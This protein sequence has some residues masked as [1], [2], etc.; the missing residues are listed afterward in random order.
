MES[1][2]NKSNNVYIL[3]GTENFQVYTLTK[4]IYTK[5]KYKNFNIV[6]SKITNKKFSIFKEKCLSSSLLFQDRL[7]HFDILDEPNKILQNNIIQLINNKL[8]KDH[9]L[10]D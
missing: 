5:Y 8:K 9:Y 1:I 7:F 6:Y 4:L 2:K 10:I 3:T